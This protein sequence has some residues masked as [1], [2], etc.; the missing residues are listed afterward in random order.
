MKLFKRLGI[1]LGVLLLLIVIASVVGIIRIDSLAKHAIERG[2]THATGVDTRVHKVSLS[3]LGGSFGMDGLSVKNPQGFKADKF[4]A[5]GNGGVAVSLASLNKPVIR[6][7]TLSLSDL[8][9]N[10][11]ARGNTYNYQPILDR[12]KSMKP[13][14]P[15]AKD[16]PKDGKKFIVDEISIR[17]VLIHVDLADLP[18]GLESLAGKDKSIDIPIHEVNLKNVGNA[19]GSGVPIAELARV[20]V[21]ALMDAAAA[22]GHG[23]LPAELLNDLTGRLATFADLS[24]LKGMQVQVAGKVG[25]ALES[26]SA[27]LEKSFGATSTGVADKAKDVIKDAGGHVDKAL[28]KAGDKL[29]GLLPGKQDKKDDK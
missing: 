7:Q 10:I 24:S 6:L 11:E 8:T 25:D 20:I 4:L 21:K 13:D 18:G 27:K 9:L 2:G 15:A 5:L 22:E 1:V 16:A 3:L 28:D 12:L 14:D 17:N 29:R 23:R 26:L 19:D